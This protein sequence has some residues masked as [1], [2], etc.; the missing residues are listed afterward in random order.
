MAKFCRVDISVRSAE[1][2]AR[3]ARHARIAAVDF[4]DT[5]VT[6]SQAVPEGA[7]DVR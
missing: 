5:E 4:R 7:L 3:A 6:A 2:K 1:V